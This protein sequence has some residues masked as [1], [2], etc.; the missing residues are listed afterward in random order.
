MIPLLVSVPGIEAGT[1][2]GLTSVVDVMP[3]VLDVMGL[4]APSWVDG[5]SLLAGMRD[6]SL[7]GRD[8]TVTTVPF[9][10]PGDAVHAVDDRR[11]RMSHANVTT[12]TTDEWALLYSP[13]DTRSELYNLR[14]DPG[15]ESNVISQ[16]PERAEGIHEQLVGFMQETGLASHMLEYRKRILF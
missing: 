11:R 12:V 10:N 2:D 6:P 8:F 7:P 14:A 4:E 16:Y 13:G 3:T 1:Y 9:A 5:R 15:Q